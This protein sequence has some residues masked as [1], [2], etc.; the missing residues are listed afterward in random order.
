MKRLLLLAAGAWLTAAPLALAASL[1][2][3]S[4]QSTKGAVLADAQG[5]TLYTYDE[6]HKG[7]STCYGECAEDWPPYFVAKGASASGPYSLVRRHDGR[8]Q[9]AFDGMPLYYWQDDSKT[10]QISG[11][12]IDGVW[13]IVHPAQQAAAG[14]ST[15]G[16]W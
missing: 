3:S 2:F 7:Q 12:G 6:D 5:M 15:G 16:S 11:D 4:A 10:G 8:L 14:G 1:P 13:H 9:W